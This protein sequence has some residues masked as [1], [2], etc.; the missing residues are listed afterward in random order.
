M[1]PVISQ[2]EIAYILFLIEQHHSEFKVLY[3]NCSITPKFHFMVHYPEFISRLVHVSI[4]NEFINMFCRCGPLCQYW[5]LRFE[6]KHS[7]FKDIARRIKCFKNIPKTLAF[8]QQRLTC[9][10]VNSGELFI[11]NDIQA[12]PGMFFMLM[13]LT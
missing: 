2:D 7:Y 8:H 12:G 4:K 6:G 5:S 11:E 13:V 3:P 1:A 9:Y 10:Y